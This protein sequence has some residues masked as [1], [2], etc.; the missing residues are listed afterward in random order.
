MSD[1]ILLTLSL[2]CFDITTAPQNRTGGMACNGTSCWLLSTSQA[3]SPQLP[4]KLLDL[5]LFSTL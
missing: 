5:V 3:E 1:A 4:V 2:V